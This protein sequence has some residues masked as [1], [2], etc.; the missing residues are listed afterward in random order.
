[1]TVHVTHKHTNFRIEVDP[2]SYGYQPGVES[3]VDTAVRELNDLFGEHAEWK[4]TRARKVY[5]LVSVCSGCGKKW[6]LYEGACAYC[7]VLQGA[8]DKVVGATE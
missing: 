5:D 1:M 8:T 2:H 6:E 4:G 3:Y 7:G